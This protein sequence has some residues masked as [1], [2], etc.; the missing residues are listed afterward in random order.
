MAPQ[1]V[2]ELK[3]FGGDHTNS[4]WFALAT[5]LMP[6][7]YAQVMAIRKSRKERAQALKAASNSAPSDDIAEVA[8]NP[9]NEEQDSHLPPQTQQE[10]SANEVDPVSVSDSVQTLNQEEQT[11][12]GTSSPSPTPDLPL[13][14]AAEGQVNAADSPA[15]QVEQNARSPAPRSIIANDDKLA[16]G[17]SVR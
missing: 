3:W 1:K 11:P 12:E 17:G 7:Q 16:T 10:P 9:V 13:P 2:P 8:T 4:V 5:I 6:K 14:N 15:L